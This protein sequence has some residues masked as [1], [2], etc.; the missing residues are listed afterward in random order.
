MD[1]DEFKN[2]VVG[3]ISIHTQEDPAAIVLPDTWLRPLREDPNNAGLN[4]LAVAQRWLEEK[5]DFLRGSPGS[6]NLPVT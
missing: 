4:P 3:M 2:H 5:E 1:Y 6:P